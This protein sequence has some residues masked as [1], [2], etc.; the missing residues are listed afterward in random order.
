MRKSGFKD[1]SLK[2]ININSSQKSCLGL[3]ILFQKKL[4]AFNQ[5]RAK[6]TQSTQNHKF[7]Q[8][9]SERGDLICYRNIFV[10]KVKLPE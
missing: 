9:F 1:S 10:R 2:K 7:K 6:Q 8:L 4:L 3:C 5:S